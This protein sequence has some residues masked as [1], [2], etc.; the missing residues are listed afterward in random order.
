MLW[1][2]S[3]CVQVASMNDTLNI[4]VEEKILCVPSSW[5]VSVLSC[6]ISNRGGLSVHEMRKSES[7]N[8]LSIRLW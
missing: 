2:C 6:S 8:E 3:R 7:K 5:M 4:D 1:A